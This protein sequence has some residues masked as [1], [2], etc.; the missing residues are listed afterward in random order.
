MLPGLSAPGI[1]P[2]PLPPPPLEGRRGLRR[3]IA[4]EGPAYPLLFAISA[5]ASILPFW[6]GDVLPFQ[7][8]GG[9]MS[10]A[11]VLAN[12][13][14]GS[15]YGR[16]FVTGDVLDPN[17]LFLFL[18]AWL[19]PL[20]G[21]VVAGKILLSLYALLLPLSADRLLVAAGRDR[22]WA[23]ASF[24]CVLNSSA[25]MGF[26]SFLG[27]MPLALYTLARAYRFLDRPI[28]ANG[29]LVTALAMLTFL[30]HAHMY[31]LLGVMALAFVMMMA[32]TWRHAVELG[33]PFA[34]SLL[35]FLPWAWG[36]F[37]APADPTALGGSALAPHYQHPGKLFTRLGEYVLA[38]W[39]GRWDDWI[40]LA[41]GL[42]VVVGL[43][44]RRPDTLPGRGRSRYGL[45]AAGVALFFCYLLVPEHTAVQASIASRAVAPAFVVGL[46]WLGMPR[47]RWAPLGM[48]LALVVLTATHSHYAARAVA[49]FN[50]EEVGP[51]WVE[52]VDALPEGSRLAV[53]I[54]DPSDATV[55]VKAH[56]HLYGYHFALNGGLAFSTFHS[57]YGR[58]ATWRRG[59]EVPWPGAD[60]RKFL[61]GEAACWFDFV[62]VRTRS[63]PRWRQLSR[64]LSYMDHSARYSLWR[65]EHERIP[66][67]R[68]DKGSLPPPEQP[69]APSGAKPRAV[70][71]ID[72]GS[73]EPPRPLATTLAPEV[74]HARGRALDGSWAQ[75]DRALLRPRRRT[76]GPRPAF[77]AT[78]A[79]L[80][81]AH[82]VRRSI[83]LP[84]LGAEGPG[85]RHPV[86]AGGTP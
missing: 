56:E 5:V 9:H 81:D 80:L 55:R 13:G 6:A 64:R 69:E 52:M 2:P 29:A 70:A 79:P 3:L 22:R 37:V 78:T 44:A 83:T 11:A 31:L 51:R 82:R 24:L 38:R 7:D 74:G 76:E 33:A 73:R 60:P 68:R 23:L 34:A 75:A 1:V 65:L 35:L 18:W 39:S 21:I 32:R 12:A 61:R 30:G 19:S 45:E 27:A 46:G 77:E 57:Y 85:A 47:L 14:E 15:L 20:T 25:L 86:P 41:L 48:S 26:V 49:R 63:L 67:C 54:D 16:T 84:A 59:K 28:L 8:Y 66:A 50:L 53:L 71:S 17:G 62:L 43:L 42:L 4:L 58:H 10:Y 40:L 72:R 36:Q